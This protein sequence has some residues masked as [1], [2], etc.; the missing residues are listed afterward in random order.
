MNNP[1]KTKQTFLQDISQYF[2]WMNK[3]DI[4]N[5]DQDAVVESVLNYGN[6][7]ETR[8]LFDIFG[9]NQVAQ[10]FKKNAFLKRSNYLPM[11]K[12]YFNLY[13]K[14]HASSYTQQ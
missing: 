6:I 5:L 2:W 9:I 13:F 10:T 3:S 11:V 14:R 8:R 4:S 7:E 1:D 12:N